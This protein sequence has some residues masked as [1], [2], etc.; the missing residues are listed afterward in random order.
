M[1]LGSLLDKIEWSG[2]I[3]T[4]EISLAAQTDLG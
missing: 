4:E 1:N 2:S 3:E